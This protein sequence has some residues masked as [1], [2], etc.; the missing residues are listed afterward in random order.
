MLKHNMTKTAT[1]N[2]KALA[3]VK[4]AE[5]T[6]A[7]MRVA[8]SFAFSAVSRDHYYDVHGEKRAIPRNGNYFPKF[9][10]IEKY[11]NDFF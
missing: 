5:M 6:V 10:A 11:C 3:G 4:A 8:D 1:F 9:D 7:E 2:F